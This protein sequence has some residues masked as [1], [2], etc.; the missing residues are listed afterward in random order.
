[1]EGKQ[2]QGKKGIA[3][4]VRLG[5]A[6]SAV[7]TAMVLGSC[8]ISDAFKID[9]GNPDL[10]LR[11]DQSFRYTLMDRLMGRDG[12]ILGDPNSDD[13]DRNFDPGIVSNRLDLLSEMDL[14]YKKYYGIRVSAAAWTDFRYLQGFD[15]SSAST[16][17]QIVNGHPA[18]GL[19]E[20]GDRHFESGG[21]LL[22]AFAF[23]KYDA[24]SIPIYFKVGRHMNFWGEALLSAFHGISYSQGPLDL[25]KATSQ[26][27]VQAKE[28]FRPENQFSFST[29]VTPTLTLM[30]Q[31]FFQWERDFAPEDGTYFASS[32]LLLKSPGVLWAAPGVYYSHNKDITPDDVG[33]FGIGLRW[34]PE[35]TAFGN[36]AAIGVFYRRF[37]D[38]LPQVVLDTSTSSYR[39]MYAD[40]IDLAGISYAASI[41]GLSLGAEFSYRH[42]MPLISGAAVVTSSDQ[43]PDCG[44][45]LGARGDT[46]HA[47]VNLVGLLKKTPLWDAGNW[48]IE[49]AYSRWL[50]VTEHEDVFLGRSSYKGF[51]RVTKDNGVIAANFTPQWLQVMSGVDVSMP[52]TGNIGMWGVSAVTDGG[53]VGDGS[54]GVGLQFDIFNKYQVLLNYVDFFGRLHADPSTGG[55]YAKGSNAALRDRDFIALTVKIPF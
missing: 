33:D 21:E 25:A 4:K 13:G 52:I 2:E 20:F 36:G 40:G 32:D 22:D 54:W 50:D 31:C 16:Y 14:I 41:F 45:T 51:N 11:W 28:V 47:L 5:F 46:I 9:T 15:N 53:G 19:S 1:M 26:P 23:A 29:Q 12:K 44:E 49:M 34:T 39:Y 37:S 17:N 42:N 7:A 48:N 55:L 38:R 3:K 24:G 27:G 18:V 8:G 10:T 43:L 30:G 35:S 6:I